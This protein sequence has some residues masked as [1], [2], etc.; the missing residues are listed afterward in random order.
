MPVLLKYIVTK[1]VI[2]VNTLKN[3]PPIPTAIL[4]GSDLSLVALLRLNTIHAPTINSILENAI[5]KV[6]PLMLRIKKDPK[7]APKVTYISGT[8]IAYISILPIL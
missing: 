3:P 7:I 1:V 6:S 5:L 2:P 8:L 4:S